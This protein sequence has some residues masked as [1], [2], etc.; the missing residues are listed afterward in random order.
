VFESMVWLHSF[1]KDRNRSYKK[2]KEI[3][4]KFENDQS[5]KEAALM[6]AVGDVMKEAVDSLKNQLGPAPNSTDAGAVA[7]E[8]L[9]EL[10]ADEE[11]RNAREFQVS[12][13]SQHQ[14]PTIDP[15]PVTPA[16][17]SQIP[18]PVENCPPH[19]H[20]KH[21][22]IVTN[23]PLLFQLVG[24]ADHGIHWEGVPQ[25]MQ[26]ERSDGFSNAHLPGVTAE[27]LL[28]HNLNGEL[29]PHVTG[30]VSQFDNYMGGMIA[31]T[32][33]ADFHRSNGSAIIEAS[34]HMH[35]GSGKSGASS[36][37]NDLLIINAAPL[38]TATCAAL[39]SEDKSHALSPYDLVDGAT[40]VT[41][42]ANTTSAR[43]RGV[44]DGHS[45]VAMFPH[46]QQRPL[47]RPAE[48]VN[49]KGNSGVFNNN[50]GS[51]DIAETSDEQI[52]VQ[53]N[54]HIV[55]FPPPQ[56]LLSSLPVS[57]DFFE[58]RESLFD[59]LHRDA[60]YW[61]SRVAL[62]KDS[63]PPPAEPL[64]TPPQP[65]VLPH[66]PNVTIINQNNGVEKELVDLIRVIV[67]AQQNALSGNQALMLSLL[68]NANKPENEETAV[69]ELIAPEEVA[70]E[71]LDGI[72]DSISGHDNMVD[73][74]PSGTAAPC[75]LVSFVADALY[76]Y[77]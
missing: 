5:G 13:P 72:I 16:P 1:D 41:P 31:L 19:P 20:N 38:P 11:L 4:D 47:L 76:S 43:N 39:R 69:V 52:M 7:L 9:R 75:F 70:K 53:T 14:P 77:R 67:A 60:P 61:L 21:V 32:R 24:D 54:N 55:A 62:L 2:L 18:E 42:F 26:Q 40:A 30:G 25:T 65:A 59:D 46:G 57:H 17:S 56:S 74:P 37:P 45:T 29:K 27:S 35:H 10:A 6:D 66:A 51:C 71:I 64:I 73:P 28:P 12:R 68:M 63:Q 58:K 50:I 44:N 23:V 15:I 48:T 8:I 3:A 49:T 36:E 34:R 22:P 33:N